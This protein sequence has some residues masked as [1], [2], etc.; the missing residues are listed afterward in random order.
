MLR[1]SSGIAAR[2]SFRWWCSAP[3]SRCGSKNSSS[4]R[5]ALRSAV[6]AAPYSFWIRRTRPTEEWNGAWSG[7]RDAAASYFLSASPYR[8]SRSSLS[9]S[10]AMS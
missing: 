9:P 10:S 5:I 2:W 6:S 3:S 7:S 8:F 1:E 4:S